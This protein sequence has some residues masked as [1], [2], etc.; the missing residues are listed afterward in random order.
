M[1]VFVK[2]REDLGRGGGWG[3]IVLM[4]ERKTVGCRQAGELHAYV[5]L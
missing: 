1:C 3:G 4:V 2:G 5:V